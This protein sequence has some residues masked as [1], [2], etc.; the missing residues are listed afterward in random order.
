MISATGS[1]GLAAAPWEAAME[2]LAIAYLQALGATS[3]APHGALA[4]AA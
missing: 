3:G 1:P 2:Q 4:R